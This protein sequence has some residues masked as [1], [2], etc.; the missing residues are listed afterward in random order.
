MI[1]TLRISELWLGFLNK[2]KI[3]TEKQRNGKGKGKGKYLLFP[4]LMVIIQPPVTHKRI[5]LKTWHVCKIFLSLLRLRGSAATDPSRRQIIGQS[6]GS[7]REVGIMTRGLDIYLELVSQVTLFT[8]IVTSPVSP[9]VWG[10]ESYPPDDP[11]VWWLSSKRGRHLMSD[12][13]VVHSVDRVE[14]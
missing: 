5:E 1:E 8:R 2:L 11:E 6:G 13:E 14:T 9:H 12:G 10:E 7:C 4:W 3:E